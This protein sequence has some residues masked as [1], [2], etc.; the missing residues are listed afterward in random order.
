VL[1]L[2]ALQLSDRW[3]PAVQRA[4]SPDYSCVRAPGTGS[5]LE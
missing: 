1:Q 2:S 4:T 5:G 3:T